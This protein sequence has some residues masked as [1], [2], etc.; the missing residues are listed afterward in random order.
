ML[1]LQNMFKEKC[2]LGPDMHI[3][4]GVLTR[5]SRTEHTFYSNI[6]IQIYIKHIFLGEYIYP[7]CVYGILYICICI[8]S[9]YM[10]V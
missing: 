3:I 8:Y 7:V 1:A 10:Y 6:Y 5:Y 2:C 4:Q 9:I